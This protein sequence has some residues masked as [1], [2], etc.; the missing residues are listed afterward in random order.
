MTSLR[1]IINCSS[2]N[3]GSCDNLFVLLM[4]LAQFYCDISQFNL[5]KSK[6]YLCYTSLSVTSY[7]GENIAY[8]F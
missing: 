3:L 7:L 4:A 8:F 5:M 1:R 6:I 2:K